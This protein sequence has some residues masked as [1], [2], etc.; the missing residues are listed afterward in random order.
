M[1]EK[2]NDIIEA[3]VSSALD[4]EGKKKNRYIEIS[5]II[6]IGFL[7]GIM[8]KTES[9]KR[10]AIGFDDY[11]TIT[12][13][14]GYNIDQIKENL[15]EKKKKD[16]EEKKKAAE[17]AQAAAKNVDNKNTTTKNKNDNK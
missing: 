4:N 17:E 16:L 6:V 7:L 9:L 11:K 5:L 2:E 13:K 15:E 3:E 10:I 1:E 14:Q 8:L 12:G